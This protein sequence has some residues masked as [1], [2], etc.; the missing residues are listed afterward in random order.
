MAAE[1]SLL[2]DHV[3]PESYDSI[4]A[5][6]EAELGQEV[7]ESFSHFDHAPTATAS[8]GQ[9]H[10]AVLKNGEVV[11][12]KIQRSGVAETVKSD[13]EILTGLGQLAEKIDDLKPYRPKQV[14]AELTRSLKRELDFG[15]EERNL[16]QFYAKFEN[17]KK[18]FDGLN[19]TF[20]FLAMIFI[21]KLI[22][23][24]LSSHHLRTRLLHF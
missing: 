8:I 7:E 13:L 2:Q 21:R 23:S 19:F 1:L 11:A 15:S 16:Y 10:K 3:A 9:V 14:V 5:T 4:C 18:G 24:Q 17:D 6:L 22:S 12:V 20:V